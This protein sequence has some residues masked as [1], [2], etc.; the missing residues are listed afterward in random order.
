LP[1]L[2]RVITQLSRTVLAQT[3]QTVVIQNC[4][5]QAVKA[6]FD[7]HGVFYT[8]AGVS[9]VWLTG[10]KVPTVGAKHTPQSTLMAAQE[11]WV[12]PGRK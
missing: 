3:C 11:S 4:R 7:A 12:L 5:Q 9:A 2:L 1:P 6:I 8:Q 10:M